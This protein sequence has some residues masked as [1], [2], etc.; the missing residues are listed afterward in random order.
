MKFEIDASTTDVHFW[1]DVRIPFE[2]KGEAQRART[3]LRS[4]LRRLDVTGEL[5]AVYASAQ[6]E[7]CDTENVLLF[8]VGA[9]QFARLGA[10]RLR[11]VR[12]FDSPPVSPSPI[13]ASHYHRYSTRRLA[14][15]GWTSRRTVG[16]RR[17]A[18]PSRLSAS[19]VWAAA[20]AGAVPSSVACGSQ[21]LVLEVMLELPEGSRVGLPSAMK[22]LVDGII[23]SFHCHDGSGE[24]AVLAS[25]I[26]N[27]LGDRRESALVSRLLLE[28]SREMGSRALVREFGKG[29]QW[30]PADELLVLVDLRRMVAHSPRGSCRATLSEAEAE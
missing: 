14:T 25:R 2:P 18:L 6:R 11:V 13:A 9:S 5:D 16:E 19:T 21:Q 4:A 29:V 8:N 15:S 22:A 23:A 24:V 20:R 28:G 30:N 10:D 1:S 26:A 27:Q 3:A 7:F 17:F 12:R